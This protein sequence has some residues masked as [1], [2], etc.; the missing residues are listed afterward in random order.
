SSKAR[1]PARTSCSPLVAP[2]K[3]L[4]SLLEH[5]WCGNG[6]ARPIMSMSLTVALCGMEPVIGRSRP[7]PGRSPVP[8]GPAQ[9]SLA[10]DQG[11]SQMRDLYPQVDGGGAGPGLQFPRCPAGSVCRL[12][13]V[14]GGPGMEGDQETLRRWRYLGRNHGPTGAP[15]SAP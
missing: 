13:H 1:S 4:A 5:G 14:A 8:A 10:Y 9:G 11:N 12:C 3:S 7:S 6:M 2:S 15:G